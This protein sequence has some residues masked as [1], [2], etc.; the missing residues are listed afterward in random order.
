MP[1]GIF[2]AITNPVSDEREAEYSDWYET[3]HMHEVLGVDGFVSVKRYQ[4]IDGENPKFMSVYEVELDDLGEVIGQLGKAGAEGKLTQ[5][6]AS[7][8][9]AT[10]MRVYEL[11]AEARAE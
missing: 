5:S 9:S 10:K 8:R 3:K 7:D 6:D 2:V 11:V 1:K 4:A